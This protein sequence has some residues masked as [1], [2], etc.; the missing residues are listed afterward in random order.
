MSL[1]VYGWSG[2][3]ESIRQM[4]KM[5]QQLRHRLAANHWQL[6][7]E[8]ELPLTCFTDAS[9]P[10]GGSSE[11][12]DQVLR[13]VLSSGKAWISRT[14]LPG[15]RPALR[16]CV[17]NFR[18][19]PTEIDALVDLLNLARHRIRLQA[20]EKVS[21]VDNKSLNHCRRIR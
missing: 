21:M 2:Y 14:I 12:L 5:G 15:G 6:L 16:A 18:S 4:V 9:D 19:G 17:T 7:N 8:T 11:F 13:E 10:T 20:P 1:L 3:E